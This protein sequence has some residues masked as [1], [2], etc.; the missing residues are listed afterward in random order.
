MPTSAGVCGCRRC[1][2]RRAWDHV[3]PVSSSSSTAAS[4]STDQI[5]TE[6]GTRIDP[7]TQSVYVDTVRIST[8][9]KKVYLVLNKPAGSCRP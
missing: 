4:R 2:P 5:V 8:Q 3:V 7:E 9:T 1:S 6:L